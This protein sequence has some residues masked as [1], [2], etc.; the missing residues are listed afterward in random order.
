MGLI[1]KE[2]FMDEFKKLCRQ[3]KDLFDKDLSCKLLIYEVAHIL[4]IK[5]VSIL[6]LSKDENKYKLVASTNPIR[7][8]SI[9]KNK[10]LS[11]TLNKNRLGINI[12]DIKNKTISNQLK[13][14][15]IETCFPIHRLNKL[16]GL[17]CLGKKANEQPLSFEEKNSL[18]ILCNEISLLVS[19]MEQ[20]SKIQKQFLST[21]QALVLA[22]ETK[23][24]Y[25]K[26]HSE[27]VARYAA[28]IAKEIGLLPEIIELL[29]ICGNIHDVGKIIINPY[30]TSKEGRLTVEEF[31]IVKS[32]VN[33]GI[34]LLNSISFP[35]KIIET[36]SHHHERLDGE[37]YPNNLTADKLPLGSRIL[38]VADAYVAMTSKRPYRNAL[39]NEEAILELKKCSG[40]WFDNEI[41]NALI[42]VIECK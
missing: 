37:G 36:V 20:Y 30:I 32:H 23:D 25:L 27:K 14:F 13:H 3:V 22:V 7:R 35:K 12:V 11:T 6:F 17:L 29:R 9:R 5:D 38:A 41:V 4:N 19:G 8:K 21:I 10:S 28:S 42:N 2:K 26:G 24:P 39:K 15:N 31:N 33:A 18:L 34:K 40:N 1:F 16:V